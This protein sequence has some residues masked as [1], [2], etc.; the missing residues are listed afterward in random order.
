LASNHSYSAK[1]GQR[2]DS[3]TEDTG[4]HT[5]TSSRAQSPDPTT[6][7]TSIPISVRATSEPPELKLVS[8]NSPPE[9]SWQWG[10]F[11]V[12]TP[13][14][15]T[16]P[17]SIHEHP[18]IS[19]LPSTSEPT[20]PLH[21]VIPEVAED[22]DDE[23]NFGRGGLLKPGDQ[24]VYVLELKGES[25]EFDISLCGDLSDMEAEEAE[26]LFAQHRVPFQAFINDPA[27]VHKDELAVQ[28]KG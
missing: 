13:K 20:L 28:W 5:P 2:F 8:D 19:G 4:E 12:Q 7:G 3:G 16:F 27:I 24:G 18:R 15:S 22:D 6:P 10:S 26:T 9:Y 11:P 23:I 1:K 17:G 25:T 21:E 14:S